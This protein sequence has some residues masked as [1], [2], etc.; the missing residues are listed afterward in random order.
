MGFAW[1]SFETGGYGVAAAVVSNTELMPLVGTNSVGQRASQSDILFDSPLA[2]AEINALLRAGGSANGG[3]LYTT[4]SPCEMCIG[5]AEIVRTGRVEYLGHDP[6]CDSL[7]QSVGYGDDRILAA[8]SPVGIEW[9]TLAEILPLTRSL[10]R[11]P[12]QASKTAA[13]YALRNPELLSAA[14]CLAE[15]GDVLSS[16]GGSPQLA[17]KAL[18]ALKPTNPTG[19][20]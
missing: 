13:A 17:V 14:R 20:F 1:K 3:V 4:L 16:L 8:V 10:L 12:S 18:S 6:A 9:A 2:H 15:S 7:L 19:H 5:A 11:R